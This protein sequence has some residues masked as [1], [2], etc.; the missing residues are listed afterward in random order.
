MYMDT[1]N[2]DSKSLFEIL[3]KSTDDYIYICEKPVDDDMTTI[4]QKMVD[5]FDIPSNVIHKFGELWLQKIHPSEQKMFFDAYVDMLNGLTD[6]HNVEYR[7][8]NAKGEWVWLRCKGFLKRDENG[9]PDLFAGM[10]TNLGRKNIVDNITGLL[11][12]YAFEDSLTYCISLNNSESGIMILNIDNFKNI[13]NLY[14]R[15]FG[16]DVLKIISHKIQSMLPLTTEFFRLDNDEFAILFRKTSYEELGQ[17]YLELKNSF[18]IQQEYE[19]KK[20]TCTFSG[21][22]VMYCDIPANE[23]NYQTFL[24]YAMAA[25]DYAKMHGK[26]RLKFFR[27]DMLEAKTRELELSEALRESIENNFEGFSLVCQP[28]VCA[29]TGILKGGEALLRWHNKNLGNISPV[30]FIP[31]L[32]KTGMIIDVGKWVFKEAVTICSEWIDYFPEFKMSINISY[33]QL[34]DDDFLD[35]IKNIIENSKSDFSNIIIELTESRFVTDKIFLN[36]IFENLRK[37]G[38]HIAMDDFGTG[39]SSL[40]ILKEVPADIVKIDRA[41]VKNIK[42]SLFDKNFIRFAVELCHNVGIKVCLEGVES[43]IEYRIVH[44]MNLDFI[45]GYYFGKPQTK[46][47]FQKNYF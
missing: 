8:K 45:Q 23:M 44:D 39:Y 7:V 1:F 21:G 43:D 24:K 12:K 5:E 32:E 46:E 6:I 37:M 30:E 9:T 47:D 29:M 16:D 26:N 42:T 36:V 18:A 4:S 31:I 10:I 25:L 40:E 19:G 11:N 14:N 33:I 2:F 27:P 35:F 38:I 28:Q 3:E 15:R 22:A 34:F 41:F 20:Y 13:N 17:I